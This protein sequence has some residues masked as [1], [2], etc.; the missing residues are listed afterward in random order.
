MHFLD[1]AKIYLK[2]AAAARAPSVSGAKNTSNT[3][4]PTAVTA[5]RAATSY[6]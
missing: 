1:Q 5:A 3:A 6:S 4:A 2:S